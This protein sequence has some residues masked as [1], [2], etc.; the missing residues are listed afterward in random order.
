MKIIFGLGRLKQRFENPI[1]AL[2]VFDG[3]HIG[4]QSLLKKV[5][6]RAKKIKGTSVV[7]TFYPHPSHVLNPKQELPFLISLKE[8]LRWLSLLGINVCWVIKFSKGFSK[9]P[10][11]DFIQ[12]YLVAKLHPKEIYVGRDFVFGSDKKGRV[13]LLQQMG[14]QN[15]FKVHAVLPV[16]IYSQVVSSTLIRDLI[17]KDRLLEASKLLNRP[18]AIWGKV[19]RGSGMGKRMGFPTVN[20]REYEGIIV[21]RGVYMARVVWRGKDFLGMA[22][23]G[24]RPSFITNDKRTSVEVHL[25]NFNSNIYGEEIAVEFLR[26]IRTEKKFSNVSLLTAQLRNDYRITKKL[27]ASLGHLPRLHPSLSYQ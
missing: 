23:F 15:G 22:Y 2:G 20:I 6:A 7:I 13:K 25:F 27:A 21:G 8:R 4:H 14:R 1:V 12:N 3:V 5:V 10:A 19:I 9:I 16:K 17:K 11:E 26:K 18:L 24:R